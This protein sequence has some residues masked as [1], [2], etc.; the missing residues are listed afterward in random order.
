LTGKPKKNNWVPKD[1]LQEENP[2][3]VAD[4]IRRVNS[5]DHLVE[6]LKFA[7]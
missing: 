4:E 6:L 1:W 7:A 5:K 2:F 3:R